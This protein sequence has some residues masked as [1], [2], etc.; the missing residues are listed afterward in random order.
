MGEGN[1][2]NTHSRRFYAYVLKL[3]QKTQ[4]IPTQFAL[5]TLLIVQIFEL[6]K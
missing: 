3:M 4:P 5:A 1:Q 6:L 2:A